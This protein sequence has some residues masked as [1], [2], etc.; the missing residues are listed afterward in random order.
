M[1]FQTLIAILIV[2]A[3]AAYLIRRWVRSIQGKAV[4]GSCHTGCST[5]PRNVGCVSGAVRRGT[6]AE[7]EIA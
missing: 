3:S 1:D 2:G 7:S 6:A 4:A 5:C